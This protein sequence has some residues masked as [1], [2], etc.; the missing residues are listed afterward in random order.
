MC[1]VSLNTSLS[2]YIYYNPTFLSPCRRRIRIAT[3]TCHDDQETHFSTLEIK[4]KKNFL[5][6]EPGPYQ[7]SNSVLTDRQADPVSL[8]ECLLTQVQAIVLRET[9][10][11]CLNNMC[12][13]T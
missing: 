9:K 13:K 11:K 5:R 7:Q 2:Q 6:C 12:G 1:A 4:K 3:R 10:K 8:T